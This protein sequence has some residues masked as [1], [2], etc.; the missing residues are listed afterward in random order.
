MTDAAPRRPLRDYAASRDDSAPLDWL[1]GIVVSVQRTTPPYTLRVRLGSGT[2]TDGVPYA[3]W[4]APQ[5][6]DVVNLLRKGPALWVLGPDAPANVVPAGAVLVPPPVPSPPAPPATTR[7]VPVAPIDRASWSPWGWRADELVQG[8]PSSRA[9]W[10][11]G[12]GIERARGSGTI[13]GASVYMR[14]VTREHGAQLA[15][16]RLGVHDFETRP[17]SASSPLPLV[18]V[19]ARLTRGQDAT[20]PLSALQINALNSGA[21]GVGLE[22]G[23]PAFTSADHLAVYA[24]AASG[25]LA[26]TIRNA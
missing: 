8:G 17:A 25:Q 26:L 7:T 15:N 24:D 10:L 9:L 12:D 14:R 13:I 5:V 23:D 22:P 4:Y 16:V 21:A 20:V 2:V 6:N 1:R 18:S 19:A 11:Y 3:A